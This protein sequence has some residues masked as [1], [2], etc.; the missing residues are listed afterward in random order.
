MGRKGRRR[1]PNP[2]SA[3]PSS[4]ASPAP[5][6]DDAPPAAAAGAAAT[7]AVA[8]GRDVGVARVPAHVA[9]GDHSAVDTVANGKAAEDGKRPPFLTLEQA[10]AQNRARAR[11]VALQRFRDQLNEMRSS[12]AAAAGAPPPA[13]V[14]LEE[15]RATQK[16]WMRVIHHAP[17]AVADAFVH[18]LCSPP[19]GKPPTG[20]T[21]QPR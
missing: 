12:D 5:A 9:S 21:P 6:R 1:V 3:T 2:S 19:T 20:A 10:C 16:R 18:S 4:S 11:Q 7:V 17:R 13:P 14:S 15:A 8:G